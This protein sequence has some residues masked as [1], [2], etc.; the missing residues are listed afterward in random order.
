MVV[1]E[2]A[3][4]TMRGER[5]SEHSRMLPMTAGDSEAV[6]RRIARSGPNSA[7]D[8][9]GASYASKGP[10]GTTSSIGMKPVAR[11]GS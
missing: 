10:D 6:L 9:S 11:V 2:V 5:D 7:G 1:L 8:F 4:R 3:G